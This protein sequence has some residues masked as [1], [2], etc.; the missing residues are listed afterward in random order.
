MQAILTAF[1]EDIKEVQR[2][3]Y[4]PKTKIVKSQFKDQ[5]DA[6]TTPKDEAGIEDVGCAAAAQAA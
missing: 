1:Y 2:A 6:G 3:R 4:C 5:E